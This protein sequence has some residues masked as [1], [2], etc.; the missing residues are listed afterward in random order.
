MG[1][2]TNSFAELFTPCSDLPEAK[3]GVLRGAYVDYAQF[4]LGGVIGV[5]S[6]CTFIF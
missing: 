3:R 5:S 4:P 6:C 2:N 1:N